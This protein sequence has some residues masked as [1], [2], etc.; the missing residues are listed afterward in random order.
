MSFAEDV[1]VPITALPMYTTAVEPEGS[2]VTPAKAISFLVL[3]DTLLYHRYGV[4]LRDCLR[5]AALRSNGT[6]IQRLLGDDGLE[7][8]FKLP[9]M[10]SRLASWYQSITP[11]ALE[12]SRL[13]DD[14]NISFAKYENMY[15]MLSRAY[16][17]WLPTPWAVEN[18][19][20]ALNLVARNKYKLSIAVEQDPQKGI[21]KV[22]GARADIRELLV[23]VLEVTSLVSDT[24]KT[25]L[26]YRLPATKTAVRIRMNFEIF[27]YFLNFFFFQQPLEQDDT[28]IIK[29]SEDGRRIA[30]VTEQAA[31]FVPMNAGLEPQSETNV[32]THCVQKG[33]EGTEIINKTMRTTWEQ[34]RKLVRH[35]IEYRHGRK[36][37]ARKL[38]LLAVFAADLMT[39]WKTLRIGYMSGPHKHLAR[40]C[41]WC[42][43]RRFLFHFPF[44]PAH[45]NLLGSALEIN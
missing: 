35:G 36:R 5:R 24:S 45:P 42:Q 38:K 27:L 8:L 1:K 10:Q 16:L 13:R 21:Q 32:I 26:P 37:K 43:V 40:P 15:M 22:T 6:F 44:H 41:P 19:H 17:P 34:I 23:S 30:N 31:V 14:Q 4:S 7:L 28:L 33:K 29:V 25:P 2:S 20:C 11:S 12:C 39:I 3:V 9:E 18:L